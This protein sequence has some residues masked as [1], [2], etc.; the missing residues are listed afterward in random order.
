MNAVQEITFEKNL[1]RN[2]RYSSIDSRLQVN[3]P[4]S[5]TQKPN[6]QLY[7][8]GWEEGL[9]SNE[10]LTVAKQMLWKKFNERNQIP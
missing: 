6:T 10:F 4:E 2:K 5:F 3:T 9:T 8:E 7:P 1:I